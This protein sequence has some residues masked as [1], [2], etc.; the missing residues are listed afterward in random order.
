MPV[1]C[2]KYIVNRVGTEYEGTRFEWDAEK[3]AAN[4]ANHDGVTFFEAATVFADPLSVIV[5]DDEHSIDEQRLLTI[6]SSDRGRVLIVSSPSAAMSFASSAPAKLSRKRFVF[7]K[8]ANN[9]IDPLAKER[10]LRGKK[11]IRRRD[12]NKVVPPEALEP[13][14]IKVHVSMTLDADVLEY[15]KEKASR[16]GA[17]PYQ[18]RINQVLRDNIERERVGTTGEAL[19]GADE[20]SETLL[21]E[22]RRLLPGAD[23]DTQDV[24]GGFLRTIRDRLKNRL[25]RDSRKNARK[26]A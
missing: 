2:A 6:G 4:I 8:K 14:N 17:L 26:L 23:K 13:R 24:A 1:I 18:S 22:I 12:A 25:E 21:A 10:D 11:I 20:S 19:T 5:D 16:P 15:F 9:N 3:A 7:M